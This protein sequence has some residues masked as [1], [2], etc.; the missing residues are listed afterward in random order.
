MKPRSKILFL[1]IL[2]TEQSNAIAILMTLFVLFFIAFPIWIQRKKIFFRFWAEIP[3]ALELK[4][5]ISYNCEQELR[6]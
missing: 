1:F 3:L 6:N 4:Q 2:Y 5:Y